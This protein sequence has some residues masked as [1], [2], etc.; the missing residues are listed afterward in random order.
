MNE[1]MK[2]SCQTSKPLN[3][4]VDTNIIIG[5]INEEDRLHKDCIELVKR[6][7]KLFLSRIS[8]I[9]TISVFPKKALEVLADVFQFILK[10]GKIESST[11][12]ES[13]DKKRP[14]YNNINRYV[15]R[16]ALESWNKHRDAYDVFEEISNMLRELM[17]FDRVVKFVG[18]RISKIL[19]VELKYDI[20]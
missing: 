14:Q 8:I 1:F 9:E 3:V 10:F 20:L 2:N 12:L 6:V 5:I 11:L 15:V 4:A 18:D 16:Y 7:D 19:G 13:L 17:E